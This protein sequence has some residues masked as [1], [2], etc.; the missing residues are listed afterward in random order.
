M[1]VARSMYIHMFGAVFGLALSK[2]LKENPSAMRAKSSQ[3]EA[4]NRY[5]SDVSAMIGTIFLWM[6]RHRLLSPK[7]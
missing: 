2:C 3:S 6:L 1:P 4:T 5:N 7:C